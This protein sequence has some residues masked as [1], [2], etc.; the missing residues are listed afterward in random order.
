MDMRT[1]WWTQLLWY[2]EVNHLTMQNQL[3]QD[4]LINTC[5]PARCANIKEHKTVS[6]AWKQTAQAVLVSSGMA[7]ITR[8]LL[9]AVPRRAGFPTLCW[10]LVSSSCHP[11]MWEPHDHFLLRSE[12]RWALPM[13]SCM[14]S[15]LK[16]A[17]WREPRAI[18]GVVQHRLISHH[19]MMRWLEKRIPPFHLAL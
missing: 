5:F 19:M 2:S 17:F 4:R 12:A 11:S 13:P 8:W 16:F 14:M 1:Q 10:S 9:K 3:L 15:C 7:F 6:A 18:L